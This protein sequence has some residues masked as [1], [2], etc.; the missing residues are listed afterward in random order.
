[1]PDEARARPSTGDTLAKFVTRAKARGVAEASEALWSQLRGMVG[2]HVEIV[3]FER[4]TGGVPE[5]TDV[6]AVRATPGDADAYA[7][8]I[9]TDS[10][11]TF[12]KRLTATTD[13]W[14]VWK[15]GHIV[16]ATWVTTS[17]A[18]TSELGLYFCPPVGSAYLYESY[19]PPSARGQG[20]YTFAL[21]AIGAHLGEEGMQTMWIGVPSDNPASLKAVRNAGFEESFRARANK[22]LARISIDIP[23]SGDVVLRASCHGP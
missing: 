23:R 7:R 3:F 15:G 19:T 1:M 2:S 18:W 17:A 6:Q 12:A 5:R 21:R 10:A 13:C 11:G 20:L 8:D 16:H 14:M 22:R 4:A 9:G